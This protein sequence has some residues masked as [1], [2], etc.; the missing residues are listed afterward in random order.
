MASL[1]LPAG[2][3]A[4][5]ATAQL[6]HSEDTSQPILCRIG[7]GAASSAQYAWILQPFFLGNVYTVPLTLSYA[8]EL[9]APGTAQLV[10]LNNSG[11]NTDVARVERI[12]LSAVRVG[13]LVTQ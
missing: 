6:A 8:G 12:H 2:A 9:A 5:T 11:D 3:Y 1:S 7:I 4:V 10:C 13:S